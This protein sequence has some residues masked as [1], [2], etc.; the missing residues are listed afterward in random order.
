M[1]DI[2]PDHLFLAQRLAFVFSQTVIEVVVENRAATIV[3]QAKGRHRRPFQV[4]ARVFYAVPGSPGLLREV[5]LPVLAELRLQ[6]TPPLVLIADVAHAR[7]DARHGPMV[8][9]DNRAPSDFLHGLLFE[10]EASPYTMLDVEAAGGDGNVNMRGLIKLTVIRV[11]C[12]EYARLSALLSGPLQH[13]AGGA[14]ERL[15]KQRPVVVKE[16][17][18]QVRHGKGDVL[19]LA[20]G[21]NVL[22]LSNPLPG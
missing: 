19:P 7:Q 15:V 10:E 8:T 14:A 20:V 18:E 9:A 4:A 6:L 5:Y 16:R 11:Q 2:A 17:P 3:P 22:L 12:V 1:A 13:G 21:Q